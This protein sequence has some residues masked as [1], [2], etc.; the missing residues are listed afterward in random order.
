[1]VK[2]LEETNLRLAELGDRVLKQFLPIMDKLLP[3]INNVL[4]IFSKMP[5]WLQASV[6]GFAALGTP[7]INAA[8]AIGRLTVAITGLNAASAA[9][10]LARIA[11]F[12][13]TSLGAGLGV[14]SLG[15]AGL[16][17]GFYEAN[18]RLD[19][20]DQQ[21]KNDLEQRAYKRQWGFAMPID[22]AERARKEAQVM[23]LNN[24][25]EFGNSSM[26]GKVRVSVSA[27][28]LATGKPILD[29]SGAAKKTGSRGSSEAEKRAEEARKKIEALQ[30]QIAE[31]RQQYW[32]DAIEDL[33]KLNNELRQGLADDETKR[34]T[35]EAFR[36]TRLIEQ[37]ESR[38]RLTKEADE[39]AVEALQTT[40][41]R[42]YNRAG[43]RIDDALNRG[44]LT[45]SEGEIL[46]QGSAR[47][48]ASRLREV[49][50]VKSRMV[51]VDQS[52]LDDLRDEIN[53]YDRLGISIDNASRFMKGF[54]SQI[55]STGDIFER[56]G[57]SISQA[58]TN[59]QDL[60]G[61]LKNA[62]KQFFNDLLGRSLQN[63]LRTA[64]T[65]V[66]SRLGGLFGNPAAAT[67]G[68]NVFGGTLGG[69]PAIAFGG[70]G[71][72]TF[73]GSVFNQS[74]ASSLFQ[75]TTASGS[76]FTSSGS[77]LNLPNPFGVL[78]P[79]A[80]PPVAGSQQAGGGVRPPIPAFNLS[81]IGK[82]LA[83]AAPFL[84]LSIG[85]S[86][87]GQSTAGQILG[88][89]GGLLAG[90][91]LA[92]LLVG[93]GALAAGLGGGAFGGAAAAFLTNPFTIAAGAALLVGSFFLGRAKQRRAD[94]KQADTYWVEYSNALDKLT[95]DV[96]ANRIDGDDALVQAAAA[97]QQ[98]IDQ[99]NTIKTK[100]VRESRLKNQISD[101]DR[102]KLEPLR[103]AVA[104]QKRRKDFDSKLIPE[105]ATGGRVPGS[106]NEKRLILAHG[107][108]LIANLS[109]QTP[110][111][112]AAARGAGVPGVAGSK[113]TGASPSQALYVEV[114]L[115]T[116]TQDQIFVNGARSDGGFKV[117]LQ[118]NKR[119]KTFKEA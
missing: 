59:I 35:D 87:G 43:N 90:G 89:A 5:G 46:Q 34:K 23:A 96:R 33:N 74:T 119:A 83:A 99:I 86:L 45:S 30:R 51:G 28:P 11:G 79:N 84:G 72:G 110:E 100:S 56:F 62:V 82:S 48:Y 13:G 4:D 31:G 21:F 98:A 53:Y 97:R 104:E 109:Q 103:Q 111:L 50:E 95:K 15:A 29:L 88:G 117:I 108:E 64:L 105:F 17:L 61:S 118:Q 1:M 18:R 77:F 9:G 6:I 66:V 81:N 58:L 63:L 78:N 69:I 32:D 10:G 80:L 20:L 112:I 36:A 54:N 24:A 49:L 47:E 26:L 38:Q 16:G 39:R 14:A 8:T 55:Q 41:R 94:E 12:F 52:Y 68:G 115:G 3:A 44:Q 40:A 101:V 57:Q 37:R 22:P 2:A 25:I 102:L 91:G 106:P 113:T 60:F 116:E 107:G 75:R 65:P 70:L 27:T 19:N 93:K 114:L 76:P 85:S 42:A 73:G 67:A 71:G 92:G 7:I